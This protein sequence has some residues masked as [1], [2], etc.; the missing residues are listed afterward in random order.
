LTRYSDK[1]TIA[2]VTDGGA[3]DL[4]LAIAAE[5]RAELGRRNI[6]VAAFERK[7]GWPRTYLQRRL[8]GDTPWKVTDLEVIA[9]ALGVPSDRFHQ[10]AK[11]AS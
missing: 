4:N 1:S 11:A 2:D 6:N 5:V 7:V 9:S 8:N 10:P 3:P